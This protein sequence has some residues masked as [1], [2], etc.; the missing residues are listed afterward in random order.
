[1]ILADITERNAHLWPHQAAYV[2]EGHVT[3]HAEFAAL[4]RR[5]ANALLALGA[6][7]GDRVAILA[8]NSPQYLALYAATG[9]AGYVAVGIN[10]RLSALE[11]AGILA[12]CD[13]QFFLFEDEYASRAAEL[14]ERLPASVRSLCIGVAPP[15]TRSWSSEMAAAGAAPTAYRA[16]TMAAMLMIYTSGTT[17]KPKGVLLSHR[18]MVETA[19]EYA[20]A[21]GAKPTDR[22]LIVMP[23]YHIGGTSQLLAY[24]IVGA[25]IVLHRVFDAQR[26]L[27]SIES[28]QVTAGHFAPTMI[29]LMLDVQEQLPRDVSSLGTVCYA[30]APMSVALSRRAR[31]AFG[32]I[33]VQVYGMTEQ[34][35]G[36]VLHKH[37]HFS[38]GTSEQVGRLA[39][40]GQP[41]LNTDVKIIEDGGT[42]RAP[43]ESGEICTRSSGLMLGYWRKPDATA[44]AIG[45]GW[46]R[47]GDV[48]YLDHEGYLFVQDRKKDMIISGGENI[49]S[50]EVEEALL[51]HAS[52]L[53]AAVIGVPDPKWGETVKAIVALK[54]GQAA[55]PESLVAH[56]RERI[57]HYK[58]P[59]SIDFVK[60]LP[61]TVSTNKV[62]KLALRA[63][64]WPAAGKQV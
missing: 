6:R 8:K 30:S 44:E 39:S 28:E 10:Y 46:M 64:H 37:Q 40:A 15:G 58:C 24:L 53:E 26:I 5:S 36:T 61:R 60:A 27:D 62:D 11:Q 63:P 16:D 43:G 33:F 49:Y 1:V 12:D 9:M 50:R 7:P 52:V 59:R 17:G 23:F 3:T 51:T 14:I 55:T 47:T 34:G 32:E 4:V 57:G 41:F 42:E 25:T 54:P 21:Q 20:L 19:R 2:Y 45:D 31:A 18:G 22:M 56:C 48:G 38:E 35:I 13:P 29:Q